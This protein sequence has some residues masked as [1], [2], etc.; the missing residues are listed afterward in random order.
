MNTQGV[1]I[2]IAYKLLAEVL[3]FV[4]FVGAVFLLAEIVLPG[5]ISDR[6]N[7][8]T[9]YWVLIA[10]SLPLIVFGRRLGDVKREDFPKVIDKEISRRMVFFI[11]G[12][13]IFFLINDV[14]KLPFG[15]TALVLGCM[16]LALYGLFFFLTR[17]Q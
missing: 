3:V 14:R 5:F 13:A 1:K 16:F 7:F 11:S 10:V 15:Q 8:S 9:F 6:I 12:V 4:L 17:K 2:S